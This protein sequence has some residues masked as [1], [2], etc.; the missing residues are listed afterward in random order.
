MRPSLYTARCTLDASCAASA[1][2]QRV[3]QEAWSLQELR[4]G[5]IPSL[6]LISLGLL[7]QKASL[8]GCPRSACEKVSPHPPPL[9]SSA[10]AG[11]FPFPKDAV[12]T[13][14]PSLKSSSTHPLCP[15]LGKP[16]S[17]IPYHLYEGRAALYPLWDPPP[18]NLFDSPFPSPPFSSPYFPPSPSPLLPITSPPLFSPPPPSP[19]PSLPSPPSPLLA[20]PDLP[21][22]ML[23]KASRLRT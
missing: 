16:T 19:L 23:T 10:F 21:R 17:L 11:P 14:R 12:L 20:S 1:H 9:L 7:S 8:P 22:F 4:N 3:K 5:L 2:A 6:P 15:V 18:R 13:F